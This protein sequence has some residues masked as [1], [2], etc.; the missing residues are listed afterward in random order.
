MSAKELQLRH[1]ASE[2]RLH[3]VERESDV[4][5]KKLD[6]QLDKSIHK[7]ARKLSQFLKS[8]DAK[9]R[10]SLWT[11]D[12][13]PSVC[14]DDL[15]LDMEPEI[16]CTIERRLADLL[17]EWDEGNNM[18]Q[19]VQGELLNTF[20]EEFLILESQLCNIEQLI[21]NDDMSLSDKSDEETTKYLS[22]AENVDTSENIFDFNLS[23]LQKIAL[24]FAA[25]VL[26]PMAM[27][28]YLQISTLW[29]C[30]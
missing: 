15:W 7:I 6:K 10:M 11:W 4:I 5:M 28:T 17:R 21:Q 2:L 27:G 30:T 13:V 23:T 22:I 9:A 18:F 20:K 29:A 1:K 26:V 3:K 24:G 14:E 8:K 16:D 19:Q 12:D 25:P